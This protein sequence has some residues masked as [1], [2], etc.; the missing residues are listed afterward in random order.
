MA[1][2][3]KDLGLVSAYGAALEGGYTGTYDEYKEKMLELLNLKSNNLLDSNYINSVEVYLSMEGNDETGDGTIEKPYRTVTKAISR[4]TYPNVNIINIIVLNSGNYGEVYIADHTTSAHSVRV[5]LA[6]GTHVVFSQIIVNNKSCV[7][8]SDSSRYY[9]DDNKNIVLEI[10]RP[11]D[12]PNY[13]GL[14][15]ANGPESYLQIGTDMSLTGLA[16]NS[17]KI[18]IHVKNNNYYSNSFY[19]S[20]RG[21]IVLGVREIE[22]ICDNVINYSGN[23]SAIFKAVKKGHILVNASASTGKGSQTTTGAWDDPSIYVSTNDDT[24]GYEKYLNGEKGVVEITEESPLSSDT[25]YT[26]LFA[27]ANYSGEIYIETFCIP[28]IGWLPDN[29]ILEL[30]ANDNGKIIIGS[31]EYQS[32]S[33]VRRIKGKTIKELFP[34]ATSANARNYLSIK[35]SGQGYFYPG[36]VKIGEINGYYRDYSLKIP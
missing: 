35:N 36:V 34:S 21:V 22:L 13:L 20:D 4:E 15:M 6:K 28:T 32:N 18:K 31:I 33:I 8:T 3:P 27:Q 5:K 30:N 10:T 11:L 9:A 16:M 7:V 25:L 29:I 14:C 24:G 23:S 2:E 19:A 17:L 12:Y 1:V 26:L